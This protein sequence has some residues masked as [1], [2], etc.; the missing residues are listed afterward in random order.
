MI[1]MCF[2]CVVSAESIMLNPERDATLI[3]APHGDRANGKGESLFV[4]RTAQSENSL[5][6]ALLHFNV[7][8]ALPEDA[9]IEAVSLTLQMN[10]S[11]EKAARI[12]VHRVLQ[13]WREGPSSSAGGSGASAV[14]GDVTWLHTDF[15]VA[16]WKRLGGHFVAASSAEKEVTTSASYT[17]SST[18]QLIANVRHWLRTPAQNYGWILVGDENTP[19]SAKSFAS[20]DNT[21]QDLRPV[22]TITYRPGNKP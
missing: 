15:D 12:S 19:Q 3:E 9:V 6:R 10:P 7:A 5:R 1:L 8:A 17:W 21:E 14:N 2:A 11:N 16:Y 13:D 20:R 4:G 18:P 22:L